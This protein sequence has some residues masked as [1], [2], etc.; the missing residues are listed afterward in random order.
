MYEHT[1]IFAR[2]MPSQKREIILDY[3][4]IMTSKFQQV[5]FVGDGANDQ[6][7][8]VEADLGLLLGNST[9]VSSGFCIEEKNVK[10]ILEITS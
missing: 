10:A 6:E 3:R 1:L 5:A 2:T 4:K 7:A 8:L 9:S